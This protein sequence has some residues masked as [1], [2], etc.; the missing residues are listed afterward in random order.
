MTEE[1]AT[2]DGDDVVGGLGGQ[3]S[4][5]YSARKPQSWTSRYLMRSDPGTKRS[6]NRSKVVAAL[7]SIGGLHPDKR[8]TYL[9]RLR[10]HMSRRRANANGQGETAFHDLADVMAHDFVDVAQNMG[11]S[12]DPVVQEIGEESLLKLKKS[13][14]LDPQDDD[15]I[16]AFKKHKATIGKS[17]FEAENTNNWGVEMYLLG[18]YNTAFDYFSQALKLTSEKK[19]PAASELAVLKAFIQER[20]DGS[21]EMLY[22][23]LVR[24]E[25]RSALGHKK[26]VEALSRLNYPGD[27]GRVF[28]M[29]DSVANDGKVSLPELTSTLKAK[30]VRLNSMDREPVQK[31][32]ILSNLACCSLQRGDV[33]S[34]LQNFREALRIVRRA[35][36]KKK[37][38]HDNVITIMTNMATAYIHLGD[39]DA[40]LHTLSVVLERREQS[41]GRLHEDAMTVLHLAG[42][43]FLV[44]ANRFQIVHDRQRMDSKKQDNPVLVNYHF[45]LCAFKERLRR[46]QTILS[47]MPALDSVLCDVGARQQL[48]LHIA[49][50][51]EIVAEVHDKCE[52]LERARDHLMASLQYKKEILDAAD[53][54]LFSTLNMYASVCARSGRDEEALESMSL[55][56]RA[57]EELFGYKSSAVATQLFHL[58]LLHL[59]L[60]CER[61]QRTTSALHKATEHLQQ[62]LNIRAELFGVESEEVASTAQLLGSVHFATGNVQQARRSFE[63]ALLIRVNQT[64]ADA[65]IACSAHALGSLC[66]RSPRR[67]EEGLMLLQKAAE[68]RR[69]QLGEGSIHLAETLHELGSGLL[70]RGDADDAQEGLAHLSQAASI[71]EEHLGKRNLTYAASLHQLGQAHLLLALPSEAK[72][73]LQASLALREKLVGKHSAQAASSRAALGVAFANVGDLDTAMG[74]LKTAYRD[75]EKA[76]GKMHALSADTLY[77]VGLVLVRK[78]ESEQA[79]AALTEALKVFSFLNDADVQA[80]LA[81]SDEEQDVPRISERTKRVQAKRGRGQAEAAKESTQTET[82]HSLA[83]RVFTKVKSKLLPAKQV[84]RE[85]GD[86]V[87]T[88][89]GLPNEEEVCIE[90]TGV[91][92]RGC[93]APKLALLMQTL[94]SVHMDLREFSRSR[95][96]LDCSCCIREEVFGIVSKEV[97][98]TMHQFGLLFRLCHDP[99]AALSYFRKALHA[100]ERTCGF[101][102]AATAET[103]EQLAGVLHELGNAEEA[104]IFMSK[105]VAVKEQ[106][107]SITAAELE[108]AR[109]KWNGLAAAGME[110]DPVQ[111]GEALPHI[112]RRS[113]E[114]YL[115]GWKDRRSENQNEAFRRYVTNAPLYKL[116]FDNAWLH[117]LHH[118]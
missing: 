17:L 39:T 80:R 59:R 9:S 24:G 21:E 88:A 82:R 102:H 73:Y 29:L 89:L 27:P 19:K 42:Y 14:T 69:R 106:I 15:V 46:Q 87:S 56:M 65:T 1:Q 52:D 77:Q 94:A 110:Y 91:D 98:E 115:H 114:S 49:R 72:L 96:W 109:E 47:T 26:F 113:A 31:G 30:T 62:C 83:L 108:Q 36:G 58:G 33:M 23:E 78:Q 75:R 44:K 64:S 16:A 11:L 18:D 90:D 22:T 118:C 41:Q 6:A 66:V 35:A 55:A 51:H 53:P 99:S 105:A 101:V 7:S 85:D 60:A 116:H 79:L 10:T 57:S 37:D 100:R 117:H 43:A 28:S 68:I 67:L 25:W 13:G 32:I 81:D 63:K 2:T 92:I 40:A 34:A 5:S 104:S 76:L 54:D 8:N 86:S 38:S 50:S 48:E 74:F 3:Q 95:Y 112:S 61:K 84:G 93:H 71:R 111:M 97:G 70:L 20:Y 103:C 107:P 12:A 45:A 4:G